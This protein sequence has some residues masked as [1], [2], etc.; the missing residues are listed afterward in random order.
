M[1][2]QCMSENL[3][4]YNDKYSKNPVNLKKYNDKYGKNPVFAW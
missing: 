2:L 1:I 3:K 4:K